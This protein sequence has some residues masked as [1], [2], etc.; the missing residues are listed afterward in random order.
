MA[1]PETSGSS[2]RRWRQRREAVAGVQAAA[3][4]ALLLGPQK[5]G[6]PGNCPAPD[7]FFNLAASLSAFVSVSAHRNM[8]VCARE[9]VRARVQPGT[10]VP[11]T[12]LCPRLPRGFP[13]AAAGPL[14]AALRS[15]LL[16]PS[17][18][19][20]SLASLS[21]WRQGLLGQTRCG[22][23]RRSR[24]IG[25]D[26]STECHYIRAGRVDATLITH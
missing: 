14:P 7:P 8:R 15:S 24:M 11:H 22:Y 18:P 26:V 1:A 10:L 23:G 17:P 20:S 12:Q 9:A 19:F 4:A 21:P 2:R 25:V 13:A 3:A 5:P 6:C 16:P